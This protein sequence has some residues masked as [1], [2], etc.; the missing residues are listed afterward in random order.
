MRRAKCLAAGVLAA[1]MVVGLPTV[2][3]TARPR[4]GGQGTH[5]GLTIPDKAAS[6]T[7][8]TTTF[9]GVPAKADRVLK[10][11]L[12]TVA[13][14]TEDDEK[15]AALSELYDLD[16]CRLAAAKLEI[17]AHDH[18]I[19][20]ADLRTSAT[21]ASLREAA[22]RAYVSGELNEVGSG[23]VFG[24]PS[25]REMAGVYTGVALGELQRAV[26][27]YKATSGSAR[28]SRSDE[29]QTSR[30]IE[31]TL[32]SLAKVRARA[33]VLVHKASGEYASI[34]RRLLRLVGRKEFTRLFTPL[35][36]GSPFTG[37]NLAGTDV[38]H[39]ASSAQGRRAAEAARKFLGVP[40]VFGGAGKVGID[41]SGLTMRAWAAAGYSLAHSATLQWEESRP[42]SLGRL[43][44]GD[45]LFYHFAHDGPNPISHVVMY[46]GSGP[47]GAETVIQAAEPGTNV[48]LDPIFFNGVVSAGQ[49]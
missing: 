49:P 27:L 30:Q 47:F 36:S 11:L 1:V 17:A 15:A 35:P 39:V 5:T 10:R 23:L 41:C 37:R 28:A 34:S 31:R 16:R 9:P 12:S 4:P 22:I 44:P 45:L 7:S 6:S 26:S 46:L 20:L 25:E 2:A 48:E 13:V 18:R 32:A 21:G 14:I 29:V 8:T 33:E 40:Y 38:S 43:E 24:S 19:R 42:V 3:A